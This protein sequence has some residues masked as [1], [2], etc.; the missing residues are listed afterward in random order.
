MKIKFFQPYSYIEIVSLDTANVPVPRIGEK[1]YASK[2][3]RR[4]GGDDFLHTLQVIVEDVIY[5]YS[6]D[7][8]EIYLSELE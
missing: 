5:D 3:I 2:Q 6:A 1:I 7:T 8:V 4:M